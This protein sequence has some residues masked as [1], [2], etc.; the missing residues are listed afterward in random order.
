MG[1]DNPEGSTLRL[2]Q[3]EFFP[4]TP[5]SAAWNGGNPVKDGVLAGVRGQ[6]HRRFLILFEMK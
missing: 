2:P 3:G 5:I 4:L 6:S 1:K